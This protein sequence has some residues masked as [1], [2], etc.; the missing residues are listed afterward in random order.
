MVPYNYSRIVRDLF[1]THPNY[2]VNI[3]EKKVKDYVECM[4][5][6]RDFGVCND[7]FEAM[8]KCVK[9]D[10]EHLKKTQSMV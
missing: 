5:V 10:G 6:N 2:S 3:C 4:I 1:G 8:K 7:L 9:H